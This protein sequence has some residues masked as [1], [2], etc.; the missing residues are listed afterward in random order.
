MIIIAIK[1]PVGISQQAPGSLCH[2]QV[3]DMP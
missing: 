1:T 2:K 3:N